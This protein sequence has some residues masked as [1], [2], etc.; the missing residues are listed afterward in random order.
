ML[1]IETLTPTGRMRTR[2]PLAP[3][4]PERQALAEGAVGL[5]I[6]HARRV[7]AAHRRLDPDEAAG[8]A[9]HALCLAASKFNPDRCPNFGAYASLVIG[10]KL[11]AAE[12]VKARHDSRT[13]RLTIDQEDT[14]DV[15]VEDHREQE[16]GTEAEAAEVIE[17]LR[18]ALDPETFA[19]LWTA[20]A[21]DTPLAEIGRARGVS[22]QRISQKAATAIEK[23]RKVVP[24]LCHQ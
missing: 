18:E 17:L 3:L 2:R 5:A 6:F 15:Q 4:D 19:L 10:H 14:G 12:K 22:R 24:E 23:A 9:F 11:A 16:P 20:F 8:V 1:I 13:T 21:E 7:V